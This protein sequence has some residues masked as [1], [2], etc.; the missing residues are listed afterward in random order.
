MSQE[1]VHSGDL[2]FSYDRSK[3]LGA[4]GY[5]EVFSGKYNGKNVAVKRVPLTN[6]DA[7][8]LLDNKPREEVLLDQLHHE[9]VVKLIGVVRD[10]KDFR[11]P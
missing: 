8:K 10:H 9:N 4:G 6:I 7:R 2:S 11:Y 3:K 1:Y 5:G